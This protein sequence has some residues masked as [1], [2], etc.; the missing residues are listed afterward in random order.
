MAFTQKSKFTSTGLMNRMPGKAKLINNSKTAFHQEFQN[1]DDIPNYVSTENEVVDG[2]RV[3]MGGYVKGNPGTVSRE[4]GSVEDTF[5]NITDDELAKVTAEGFTPDLAGYSEY[6]AGFNSGTLPSQIT[7][8]GGQVDV[9][10]GTPDE[11]IRSVKYPENLYDVGQRYREA[12]DLEGWRGYLAKNNIE[13]NEELTNYLVGVRK[14]RRR[15][16]IDD[17][18]RKDFAQKLK[19]CNTTNNN[20]DY[21][22]EVQAQATKNREYNR[23]RKQQKYTRQGTPESKTYLGVQKI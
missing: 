19:T 16:K 17:Q 3:S 12:N 11:T 20:R 6:V 1:P 2:K 8:Y 4:R 18:K 13:Q 7:K 23:K 15:R 22:Q 5:A 21:C 10:A 14:T 9:V